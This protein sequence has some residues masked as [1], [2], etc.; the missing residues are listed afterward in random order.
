[1]NWL[2]NFLR[3]LIVGFFTANKAVQQAHSAGEAQANATTSAQAASKEAEIAQ[4]SVDAPKTRDDVVVAL[5]RG[6]F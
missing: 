5:R 2:W 3:D 6:K 4:A 1:M